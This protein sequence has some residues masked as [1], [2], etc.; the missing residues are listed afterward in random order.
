[1]APAPPP[2][3][4]LP[5]LQALI[6]SQ[7]QAIRDEAKRDNAKWGNPGDPDRGYQ[8]LLTEQLPIRK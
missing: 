5:P 3:T 8:Q 2:P 1:M 6:T 7:Y 4:P